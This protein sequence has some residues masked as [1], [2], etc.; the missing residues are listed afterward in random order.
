MLVNSEYLAQYKISNGS[1]L[2]PR[3]LHNLETQWSE[4]VASQA[5]RGI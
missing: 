3:D 1:V 2:S 5:Q 4:V